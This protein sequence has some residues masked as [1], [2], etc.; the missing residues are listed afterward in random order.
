MGVHPNVLLHGLATL[1]AL[2]RLTLEVQILC[3]DKLPAVVFWVMSCDDGLALCTSWIVYG[4]CRAALVSNLIC[5]GCENVERNLVL[6]WLIALILNL[7][8]R[9]VSRSL[10]LLMD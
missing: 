8:R 9:I 7:N 6:G 4:A 10:W 2:V 5:C 3:L 1:L